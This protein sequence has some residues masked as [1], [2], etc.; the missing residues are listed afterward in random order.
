MLR[1]SSYHICQK[2]RQQIWFS[3]KNNI[4]A[5]TRMLLSFVFSQSQCILCRLTECR[6]TGLSTNRMLTVGTRYHPDEGFDRN[7][8]GTNHNT[9]Y[10]HYNEAK[11][12]PRLFNSRSTS[13]LPRYIGDSHP[14]H[15]QISK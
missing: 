13:N 10:N 7:A 11:M 14:I 4:T 5:T 6:L 8:S 3:Y 15:D 1:T 12:L 2:F 9:K